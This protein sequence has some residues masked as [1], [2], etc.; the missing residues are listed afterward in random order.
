M[1]AR[2]NNLSGAPLFSFFGKSNN[3]EIADRLFKNKKIKTNSS[4]RSARVSALLKLIFCIFLMLLFLLIDGFKTE[5]II[6]SDH[7]E[8]IT[9]GKLQLH[10]FSFTL[11]ILAEDHRRL[12]N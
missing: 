11:K 2:F 9:I 12:Y 1:T 3:Q 8:G 6:T 10:P 4:E 7:P 5:I